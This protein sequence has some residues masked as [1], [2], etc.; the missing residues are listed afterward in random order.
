[1]HG[2]F[3]F[4]HMLEALDLFRDFNQTSGMDDRLKQ[5]HEAKAAAQSIDMLLSS[6]QVLRG[7]YYS[8]LVKPVQRIATYPPCA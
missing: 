2:T 5:N 7:N 1:M 3:A 6:A 4:A 8:Y